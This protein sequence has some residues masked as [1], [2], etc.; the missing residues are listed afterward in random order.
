MT[1]SHGCIKLTYIV[2]YTLKFSFYIPCTTMGAIC[3]K[4]I[5]NAP[6]I[7]QLDP[8]IFKYLDHLNPFRKYRG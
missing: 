8:D 4:I 3:C 1:S 5:T 6:I 2:Q 7:Y